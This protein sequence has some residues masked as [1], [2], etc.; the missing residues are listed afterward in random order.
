M[1]PHTMKPETQ[2]YFDNISIEIIAELRKARYSIKAAIA[3]LTDQE[4]LGVMT[5]KARNGIE[6]ELILGN[7]SLKDYDLSPMAF[8]PLHKAGGQVFYNGAADFR[9]GGIMHNKF[10]VIDHKIIITGSYNWTRQARRNEENIVIIKDEEQA[11]I[12]LDKF[13]ELKVSSTFFQILNVERDL[14]ISFTSS[15]IWLDRSQKFRI[16]WKVD[17]ATEVSINNG[18][19]LVDTS[20]SL[21]VSIREDTC[22]ILE[23]SNEEDI[24]RKSIFVRVIQ[25]PV[26]SY[27][28]TYLD[29]RSGYSQP[30]PSAL[31]L[32]DSYSVVSGMSLTLH[33]KV[34]N[35]ETLEIDGEELDR[36][37]GSMGFTV[38][39]PQTITIAAFGIKHKETKRFTINPIQIPRLERVISPLPGDIRVYAEFDFLKSEIPSSFTF[40]GN[41]VKVRLPRIRDLKAKL[42]RIGQLPG[43]KKSDLSRQNKKFA[44]VREANKKRLKQ[45]LAKVFKGSELE[46]IIE[47]TITPYE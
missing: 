12:F 7:V 34:E 32:L 31:P 21:E 18:I 17:T 42:V 25:K 37:E 36:M 16:Y 19:G 47:K 45:H 33:W 11:A 20:G 26:I 27:E 40:S 43:P 22:Y 44:E 13:E 41:P 14:E 38:E 4:V 24:K 30:L 46:Q 29:P 15:K 9:E 5:E 6:V 10:A 28:L 1:T 3:W 23:A 35:A 39:Y 2:V 8:I